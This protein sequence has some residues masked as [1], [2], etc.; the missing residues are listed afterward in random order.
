MSC[1]ST[2]QNFLK[3]KMLKKKN[4]TLSSII[5]AVCRR[6]I[7][8]Q[9]RQSNRTL[10]QNRVVKKIPLMNLPVQE[11]SIQ[12]MPAQPHR[13]Y[14]LPFF[15]PF[16]N[17]Q[18]PPSMCLFFHGNRQKEIRILISQSLCIKHRHRH[19]NNQPH[20][21]QKMAKKINR[22]LVVKYG[23]LTVIPYNL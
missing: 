2:E 8:S 13:P 6:N 21:V 17:V 15:Y 1:L 9:K 18:S 20:C 4:S 14:E 11:A 3:R 23:Y 10:N 5:W 7:V 22:S 19:N 16:Y 12:Q